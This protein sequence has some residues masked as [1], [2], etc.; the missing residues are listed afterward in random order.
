MPI[1]TSVLYQVVETLNDGEETVL[2]IGRKARL[3]RTGWR[4]KLG[5]S[6]E[7]WDAILARTQSGDGGASAT[8][9]LGL[10]SKYYDYLHSHAKPLILS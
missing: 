4:E 7:T 6:L 10:G 3:K 9:W 2:I 8:T 1:R 5:V